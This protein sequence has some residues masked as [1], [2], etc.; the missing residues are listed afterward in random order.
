MAEFILTRQMNLPL[1]RAQVFE[2]FA[3]AGNLEKIT[4]PELQFQIITPQPMKLKQ[5]SII[6]YDLRLRGFLIH[7]RTLISKWDPPFEFIDEQIRGPYKQWIHRH[8]FTELP[9]GDTS[10]EDIVRYRLPVEPLG[11][12][13]HFMVRGELERIFNFR[14]KAV[15][16]ILTA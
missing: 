8:V 4:P 11:D 12:L 16:E 7:W 6:E 10:I 13:L 3:D 14:Q 5:D 9:N 15:E 2:F 1:P